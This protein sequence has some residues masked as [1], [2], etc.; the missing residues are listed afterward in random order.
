MFLNGDLLRDNLGGRV[1]ADGDGEKGGLGSTQFDTLTH[2]IVDGTAITG[3]VFDS[4]QASEGGLRM[5]TPL[6]GVL[7]TVDGL[8]DTHFTHTDASG[9]FRLDPVPAGRFFVHIDGRKATNEK[10]AG[11]YYPFVGKAWES[12]AGLESSIGDVLPAPYTRRNPARGE[13]PAS[14]NHYRGRR[15]T[16]EP[17]GVC[18]CLYS[19]SGRFPV[20]G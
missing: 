10:P 5:E 20:R 15:N 4:Q 12:R 17:A 19:G 11:S 18:R 1:D 16:G 2:T 9:N 14:H 6:A 13:P 3:R 8:E 7:I